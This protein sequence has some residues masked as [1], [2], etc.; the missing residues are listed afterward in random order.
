M[1]VANG[2]HIR[3]LTIDQNVHRELARRFPLVE[4]PAFKIGDRDQIFSHAAFARHRRRRKDAT[5]VETHAHVAVRRND[6]AALVHQVTNPDQIA[7]DCLLIH[8]LSP[9]RLCVWS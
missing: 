2:I 1:R 5:V 6:I 7:L 9:L 8:E 3:T 4:R